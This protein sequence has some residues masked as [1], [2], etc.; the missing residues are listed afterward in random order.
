MNVLSGSPIRPAPISR[1]EERNSKRREP[2]AARAG[3]GRE[4]EGGQ[5]AR[6]AWTDL[7][8]GDVR[9]A[10][11]SAAG[12]S[13]DRKVPVGLTFPLYHFLS[14]ESEEGV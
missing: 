5:A 1:T 9:T 3:G 14:S 6:R 12:N 4:Q 8:G 11:D 7:R 2:C 10:G 13:W